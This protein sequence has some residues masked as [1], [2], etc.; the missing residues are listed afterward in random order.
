MAEANPTI[1]QGTSVQET[2]V[3][4]KRSWLRPITWPRSFTAI[5]ICGQLG[6][7]QSKLR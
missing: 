7:L 1:E 3:R 4:A 2:N 5:C 6:G